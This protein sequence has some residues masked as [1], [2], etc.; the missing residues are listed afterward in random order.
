[1]EAFESWLVHRI[2]E[3]VEAGEVSAHLLAELQAGV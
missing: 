2:A 3:V 1:M